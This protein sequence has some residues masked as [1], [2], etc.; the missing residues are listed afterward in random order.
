MTPFYFTDFF[1]EG[2]RAFTLDGIDESEMLDPTDPLAFVTGLTFVDTAVEGSILT[3]TPIVVGD[4][5]VDMQ[6]PVVT[7]VMTSINPVAQYSAFDINAVVDDSETGG[8]NIQS[9]QYTVNAGG[10]VAMS[11]ADGAFDSATENVTA[12]V[13]AGLAAGVYSVCVTGMDAAGLSSTPECAFLAV[14]D[15]SAGFVTGGGWINSPAGAY[16]ADPTLTARADF[17]FVSK[18][19][20]GTTVPEGDTE[21]LFKAGNLSFQST[22]YE[23]LVIAGN[24][25]QFKGEGTINDSGNYKF[26]LTA[27]DEGSGNGVDKFRM[28]ITDSDDNVVYD[29]Q[30]GDGDDAA[31]STVISGGQIVIH[32]KDS[33]VQQLKE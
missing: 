27:I 33:R 1:P 25:A 12:S 23:W 4:E 6:P 13:G 24:R 31:V 21:F 5:P 11:A 30:M 18:Y 10:P 28:K 15:P 7:N 29:N 26:M 14:Y 8:S 3:M 19:K 32:K 9:A 22:S 17:G 20:K 16:S 2:V